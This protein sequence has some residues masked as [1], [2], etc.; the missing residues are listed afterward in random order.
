ML[1]IPRTHLNSTTSRQ[2]QLHSLELYLKNLFTSLL[3]TYC[4]HLTDVNNFLI[5]ITDLCQQ[6]TELTTDRC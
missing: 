5:L 3:V 6:V 4:Y 2:L 1:K